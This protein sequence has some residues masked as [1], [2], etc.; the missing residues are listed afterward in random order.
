MGVRP[1]EASDGGMNV[2]MRT[3]P[4]V[5]RLYG[6]YGAEPKATEFPALDWLFANRSS[7]GHLRNSRS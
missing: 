1:V 7:D 6:L 4:L 5:P 3:D 2:R